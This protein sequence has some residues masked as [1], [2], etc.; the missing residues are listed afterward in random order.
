MKF[1]QNFYSIAFTIIVSGQD[2]SFSICQV[3]VYIQLKKAYEAV[4]GFGSKGRTWLAT[5]LKESGK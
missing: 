2:L 1:L 5:S 3:S 4:Y